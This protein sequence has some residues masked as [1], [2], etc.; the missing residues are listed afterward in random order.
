MA[1]VNRVQR[2]TNGT[3]RYRPYAKV[4]PVKQPPY[5]V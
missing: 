3:Y 4:K 5:E 1:N 2:A